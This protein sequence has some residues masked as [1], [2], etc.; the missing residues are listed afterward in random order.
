MLTIMAIYVHNN[1]CQS[2]SYIH[3]IQVIVPSH[4]EMKTML[5]KAN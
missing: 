1:I 5:I 3:F 4:V 2:S